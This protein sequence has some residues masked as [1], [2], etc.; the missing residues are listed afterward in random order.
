M[1]MNAC[2]ASNLPPFLS[3]WNFRLNFKYALRI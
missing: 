3:G 2:S 1:S